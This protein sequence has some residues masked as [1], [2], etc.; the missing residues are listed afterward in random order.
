MLS[1]R[2]IA[3]FAVHLNVKHVFRK[4][5][6]YSASTFSW[7]ICLEIILNAMNLSNNF[8]FHVKNTTE[9]CPIQL[10]IL[11]DFNVAQN[12]KSIQISCFTCNNCGWMTKP[13]T[14]TWQA[15]RKITIE[16][17]NNSIVSTFNVV[18]KC[19]RTNLMRRISLFL[20]FG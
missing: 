2:V 7:C 4:Q 8:N 18:F 20:F 15:L 19:K 16:N 11:C 3:L 6:K 12:G 5:I 17:L 10:N 1:P 14:T 13:K 9:N